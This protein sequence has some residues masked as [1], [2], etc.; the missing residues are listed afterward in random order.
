MT[1][2]TID[3][4][5][6]KISKYFMPLMASIALSVIIWGINVILGEIRDIKETQMSQNRYIQENS[7]NIKLIQKDLNYIQLDSLE[8]KKQLDEL[9]KSVEIN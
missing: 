8:I 5:D 7:I 4:F 3:N 2:K 9:K 1:A 6:E